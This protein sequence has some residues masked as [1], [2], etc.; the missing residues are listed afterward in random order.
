MAR[1]RDVSLNK[2]GKKSHY[3]ILF[4]IAAILTL[5]CI[6]TGSHVTEADTVQV[7]AVAEKRYVAERDAI[8]EV[9]TEKLRDA[10]AD[11][12]APIYM[13]DSAAE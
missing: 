6:S 1:K 9:T 11:S 10:A 13:H 3:G 8:D 12:V 4:V 5:V 2:H 7:G